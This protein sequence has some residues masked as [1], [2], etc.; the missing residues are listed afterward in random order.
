MKISTIILCFI[1]SFTAY[2]ANIELK[3]QGMSC[4]SCEA[5]ITKQLKRVK[6]LKSV[7]VSAENK[8]AIIE[9]DEKVLVDDASLRDAV[10]KA[11]YSI[12]E[13]IRD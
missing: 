8:N 1:L 3:I 6:G 7:K 13:I 12:T 9:L 2:A 11:G 4:G 10:K 5:S